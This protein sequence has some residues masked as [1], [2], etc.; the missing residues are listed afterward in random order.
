MNILVVGSGGREHTIAWKI[1][2]SPLCKNLF[3]LPGNAGTRQLA[4]NIDI[5]I[6]DFESVKNFV[7]AENIDLVVIGPEAPLVDGM[8]DLFAAD[9]QLCEILFIGPCQKGAMLEGS[10][11]FAKQFMSRN[12][13]PTAS[14]ETFTVDQLLN[15]KKH[16]KN[17][18]PP[19]VI[20]ADGLAAG[21]GVIICDEKNKAEEVVENMLL[22]K[23]FGKA[24]D[25]IIIEEYLEGIEI[26]VFLLT[27]GKDYVIFPEAK[28]Y[29]RIGEKDTGLNTGGMGSV[30]PVYFADFLFMQKVEERIIKPTIDGLKKEKIDFIGFIFLG[31]MNVNG[32]PFVIEYNVRMGD[33]ESQVVI[34]RIKNDLVKLLTAAAKGELKNQT[35]S[36]DKRS[37]ATIVLA[38]GGY[39]GSYEK[40]KAIYGLEN[41][42]N[43][44][45]FHAGTKSD[46]Q[47]NV[48]T[49]GGRVLAVTGMGNNLNE[50]LRIAYQE[51]S[52]IHWEGMQYR[53]DIGQDLL[54][55]DK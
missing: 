20:K 47:S 9:D 41:V 42:E 11:D 52:K 10:K 15:A 21:K 4:E 44:I 55:L 50:A 16:L 39:P 38:S 40:G 12:Q 49:N 3:V 27:D 6:S 19:I 1:R 2:Q 29:K 22:N 18:K 14:S 23:M 25:K 31:L 34:P 24:S 33:P 46:S 17:I 37:A 54:H 36:L 13:I 43:A 30:S 53:R 51:I 26:S 5:P 28:D 35:V 7:L 45:V 8:R 32:D 48:I